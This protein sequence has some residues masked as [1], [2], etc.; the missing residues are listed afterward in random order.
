MSGVKGFTEFTRPGQ[1]EKLIDI[2]GKF[3]VYDGNNEV[4]TN[5]DNIYSSYTDWVPVEA[6]QYLQAKLSL[7]ANFVSDNY[8]WEFIITDK[9][10]SQNSIKAVVN[11]Q[12]K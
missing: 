8:R 9:K 4:N 11:F 5:V 6:G 3:T 10:N 7:P 1:A 2:A 12:V